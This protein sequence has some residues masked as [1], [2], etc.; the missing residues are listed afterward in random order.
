MVV[1]FLV[2]CYFA[3]LHQGLGYEAIAAW[4]ELIW[5]VG[6]TTASWLIVAFISKVTE[7]KT[8]DRFKDKFGDPTVYWPLQL[9]T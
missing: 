1:S 3:F 9:N 5:G 7:E 8:S 4:Q 6:I 2:A